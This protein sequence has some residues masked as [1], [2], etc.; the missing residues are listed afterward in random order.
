MANV[1]A[2][3]NQLNLVDLQFL[4]DTYNNL[5]I[6]GD[7]NAKHHLILPHTQKTK[8]NSNGKQLH[9]FLEVLD[10]PVSIPAEVTIH[11]DRSPDSWT[12]ITEWGTHVQIDYIISNSS[13]SHFLV[14]PTYEENLLSDHQGTTTLSRISHTLYS[15]IYYRLDNL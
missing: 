7:L 12:H 2:R 3:D 13:I 1:Y 6:A 4:F 15:Q 11:N 14:D 5:I 9:I 10:G 8:Y